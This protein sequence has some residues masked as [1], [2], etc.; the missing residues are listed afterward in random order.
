MIHKIVDICLDLEHSSGVVCQLLAL[1]GG[2][3]ISYDKICNSG[4]QLF[5]V[6]LPEV[7]DQ[8]RALYDSAV[9]S[10]GMGGRPILVSADMNMM[11]HLMESITTN[12]IL[13]W[14]QTLSMT[15]RSALLK[16]KELN[17]SM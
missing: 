14:V 11:G 5:V 15:F 7:I 16:D 3:D 8:R 10:D 6:D 13:H 12:I 9:E 4:R 2:L 1:G 17:C